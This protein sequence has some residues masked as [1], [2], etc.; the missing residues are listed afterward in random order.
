V[1]GQGAR[2]DVG[3]ATLEHLG[4]GGKH[5]GTAPASEAGE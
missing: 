5:T 4:Q 3:A 1:E 2:S